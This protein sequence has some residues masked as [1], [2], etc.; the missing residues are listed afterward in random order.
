MKQSS[1]GLKVSILGREYFIA[2]TMSEQE[3]VGK[4]ATYLDRKMRE[5]QSS[6]RVVGVER[7]AI[8]A[9]LNVTHQLLKLEKE[10]VEHDSLSTDVEKRLE[11]ISQKIES[12][13]EDQRAT[14]V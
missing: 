11:S 1:D 5:I 10:I 12:A 2:C 4:A 14:M 7:C 3:A 8:M 13:V 6:G 9:A